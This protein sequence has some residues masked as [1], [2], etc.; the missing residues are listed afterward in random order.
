MIF[1]KSSDGE[2][3]TYW[4][5]GRLDTDTAPELEEDLIAS[6][7]GVRSLIFDLD[8]LVYLSSSGLRTFLNAQKLMDEC[9]GSMVIRNVPDDARQ[10]MAAVGFTNIF[11]IE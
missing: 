3:L 8:E 5:T 7:D 11:Q 4:I 1:R 6:T 9:D 10:I 2:K